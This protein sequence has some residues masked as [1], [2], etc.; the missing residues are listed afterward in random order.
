MRTPLPPVNEP[1]DLLQNRLQKEKRAPAKQRL[2]MLVLF[3]SGQ[4]NTRKAAADHLAL[5]RNTIAQWIARYQNDGLEALLEDQKRGP[6]EGQRTLNEPALEALKARLD[7]PEGFGSYGEIETWLEDEF[8]IE[9]PYKTV[10]HLVRYHLGAKLKVG[11]RSH[12]KKNSI[13]P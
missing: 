7:T 6:K 5:H 13:K 12:V 1:L 3:K 9:L 11:R 10:H 2:H 8:G 4:A